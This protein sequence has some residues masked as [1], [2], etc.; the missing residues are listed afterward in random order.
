LSLVG[1]YPV[2]EQDAEKL[3]KDGIA[4]RFLAPAGIVGLWRLNGQGNNR[5]VWDYTKADVEYATGN[6][7]FLDIR[8]L[9][10]H[11]LNIL[12]GKGK[13]WTLSHASTDSHSLKVAAS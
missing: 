12:D 4:C 1:N 2:H 6:S 5:E 8:I 9:C 10:F 7:V 3:T 13:E 11:L